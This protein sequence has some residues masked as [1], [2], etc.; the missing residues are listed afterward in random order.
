[1]ANLDGPHKEHP[2]SPSKR[3]SARRS[4]LSQSRSPMRALRIRGTAPCDGNGLIQAAGLTEPRV[5]KERQLYG[6]GVG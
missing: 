3:S 6:T 4:A 1:M 5:R 2:I